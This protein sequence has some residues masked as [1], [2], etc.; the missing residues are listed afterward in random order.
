MQL[1]DLDMMETVALGLLI[2][3]IVLFTSFVIYARTVG[4]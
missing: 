1:R 3:V 2:S 4:Y